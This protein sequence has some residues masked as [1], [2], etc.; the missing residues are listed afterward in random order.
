MSCE[1]S[2]DVGNGPGVNAWNPGFAR[3][4]FKRAGMHDFMAKSVQLEKLAA[5]LERGH[6]WIAAAGRASGSLPA[7][8][9]S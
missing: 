4:R 5:G 6:G 2:L 3:F 9:A 7:A 8:P 1:L